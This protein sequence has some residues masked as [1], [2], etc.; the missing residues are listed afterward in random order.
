MLARWTEVLI[1]R[2]HTVLVI[3]GVLFIAAVAYGLGIG[4]GVFGHLGNGGFDDPSSQ[5]AKELAHEQALFGN[6]NVDL[7]ALYR[8]TDHTVADPEFRQEVRQALAKIPRGT[9]TSVLTYWNTKDAGLVSTDKHATQVLISLTG[10][11]QNAMSDMA[12]KVV[13]AL[14]DGA[15]SAGLQ[16]DI[17]GQWAVYTGVNE[18]V[19]SDLE[20][21]ELISTPFVVLLSLLIFGSVVAALMPGLVGLTAVVGGLA[22][23]RLLTTFTEVS[24]FSLNVISLLGMGLAIDYS[25]FVI[26]RYREELAKLPTDDKGAPAQAIR[27]A[28]DTAGRTVMF[29]GLTVAAAMSSLLIFPQNFLR[30][31]GY[32]GIA[33]VVVAIVSALTVLPAILLLL[34]RRI[35]AGR[36]PWRRGRAVGVDSDHGAWARLAHGVMRHP[37]AVALVI[38]VGLLAIAS[39]F[40][41]VKWGS[42]DY[43]VLPPDAPAHV[44]SVKL[45][46]EFGGEKST[47]NILVNGTDRAAI[48]A[49]E[50]DLEAA[51]P[52]SVQPVDQ[53]DGVT[54]LRA[55]WPGNSQTQAS[56]QVVRDLR[57]VAGPSG[58]HV[59][60]GGMAAD[61]VDLGTSL[62]HHLPWMALIIVAVMLM[63]LFLAFGS[64]V[65]PVKAVIMNLFSISASF[66][67]ITWIFADGHLQGLLDYSSA[68]F[69]DMTQPIFMLAIL[70]GLSMDYEVFLLSRVREQWDRDA[71]SGLAPGERNAIAV[72]AGVQKTGRII[73]SAA[74]LLAVVIG[75]F[76][77]S[78]VVFM[79]MIGVG[80]LVALLVDAT[81]V[82][83]LLVPATMKLLGGWNWYAPGPLKRFWERYGIKEA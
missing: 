46:Q 61:T 44:A 24:V 40:L 47:A 31:L 79:K 64:V 22:V 72:A 12:D 62:M 15:R 30:S 42:V 14:K 69:L 38:V 39:P 11:D 28:L 17:G 33:A 29:S 60:I 50:H 18:T 34:G 75:A 7:I 83:A 58:E 20:H 54:L 3:G 67:V 19:S 56:Q 26:S 37:I 76:S 21:A 6:K 59:L 77:M 68:G 51:A 70:V 41:G 55:S 5:A 71:G 4:G 13:P 48:A 16:V 2:A 27:T 65:L 35:D 57:S 45:A 80:M 53:Q 25:L 8:S 81:V 32:G 66:G 74:L 9:T 36:M 63:L 78:G 52:V 43:R 1:H 73:T 49:Y 82:R 23:V 10:K